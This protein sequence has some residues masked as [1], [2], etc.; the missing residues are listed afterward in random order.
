MKPRIFIY[1]HYLEIG[2]AETS[3]IG[4]LQALDPARVAVDLFLGDP[5]GEMM[6][7]IPAWVNVL[8]ARRAYTM[9]ERPIREVVRAGYFHIAAARLLAKL[10]FGRYARRKRPIDGSAIFGYVA[11]CVTPLLPSLESLGRYDLALSFL[12]PHDIV[13]AKVRS[14]RKIC[15]I[16]TDYTRIDVNAALERPVWDGY[17]RI[18]SISGEV[19]HAFCRTFPALESKI[20]EIENILSPDFVRRRA[21]AAPLPEDMPR[22]AG[23][24][25]LLTIGRFSY[26]KRL[27]EIPAI[28]RQLM[29][30]GVAVR[31]YIIGYGGSDDYIRR[32][33]AAESMDKYVVLLGKRENP[34]PYLAACDWY[35]QPSRYEGKSVT[36]REAQILYKPVVIT[37]YPTA[38]SQVCDGTDGIIVPM[39]LEA[40]ATAMAAAL[41]DAAL[42]ERIVKNLAERDYGNVREAEK[43]YAL[44]Q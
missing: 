38:D 13:L 10:L 14:K 9:V 19:A 29:A 4:L 37:A 36:V 26:P 21:A 17:D 16:H 39:P 22:T 7:Y 25:T 28:C 20:I 5:R 33:I 12:A 8:P 27:E 34:Y 18:V 6:R 3:L 35:V 11:R 15:W 42:R 30:R 41:T 44:A 2:G 31:W 32:A 23:A 40:C 1:I 43:I 24:V